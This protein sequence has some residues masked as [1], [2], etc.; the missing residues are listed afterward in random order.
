MKEVIEM[1]AKKNQK[2]QERGE[3]RDVMATTCNEV[4]CCFNSCGCNECYLCC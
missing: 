4:V 2:K 3:C 1:K